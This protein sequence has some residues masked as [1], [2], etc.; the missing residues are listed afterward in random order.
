SWIFDSV[1]S[2]SRKLEHLNHPASFGAS[3]EAV[4]GESLGCVWG[5]EKVICF[6][7]SSFL[8]CHLPEFPLHQQE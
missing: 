3:P 7:G 4:E 6:G 2:W 8:P 1:G 5:W